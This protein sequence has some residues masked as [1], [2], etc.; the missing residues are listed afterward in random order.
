MLRHIPLRSANV[1]EALTLIARVHADRGDLDLASAEVQ[2][3]IE[4][5]ALHH[6]AYLLLGRIASRQGQWAM[7]IQQLERARYLSSDAPIIS[8]HLAEAYRQA[9]R[10]EKAVLEYRNAWQKLQKYPPGELLDGV[11]VGWLAETCQ[12]HIKSISR[13]ISSKSGA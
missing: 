9:G 3:A 13:S 7:A 12:R 2:R 6:D 11:A 5:D 4:I 8:F 1:P 10:A